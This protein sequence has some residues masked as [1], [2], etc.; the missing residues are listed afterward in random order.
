[1]AT[2]GRGGE[3]GNRSQRRLPAEFSGNLPDLLRSGTSRSRFVGESAVCFSRIHKSGVEKR[4][5]DRFAG[6][7]SDRNFVAAASAAP[8]KAGRSARNRNSFLQ[9]RERRGEKGGGGLSVLRA[10]RKHEGLRSAAPP[11]F[12][13]NRGTAFGSGGRNGDRAVHAA[14]CANAP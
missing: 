5:V 3:K 6:L 4:A 10:Q 9:R 14:S 12:V 1:R 8:G 11:A 13:G 7:L 2:I